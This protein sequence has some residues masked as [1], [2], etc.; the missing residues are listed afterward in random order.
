[1]MNRFLAAACAAV[2]SLSA[3]ACADLTTA[4]N[5]KDSG[6]YAIAVEN[7]RE[8]AE[9]GIPEAQVELAR[10]YL[11]GKGVEKNPQE[12]ARLF[13]NA[14]SAGN[15][16]AHYELARLYE[17]GDGVVKSG[18]KA[19]AYY[20]RAIELGYKGPAFFARGR[21]YDRGKAVAK[22]TSL[23]MDLYHAAALE[24]YGRA[25]YPLGKL[26]EARGVIPAMR[27]IPELGVAGDNGVKNIAALALYYAAREA[28]EA[29]AQK[30]IARLES[31]LPQPALAQAHQIRQK[32]YVRAQKERKPVFGELASG[33]IA[34]SSTGKR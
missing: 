26:V 17:N 3:G 11:D 2:L 33:I 1:M 27:A 25:G 19:D 28:G 32:Y 30:E 9:F 8:L 15:P 22:N 20:I 7:Y 31:T 21:M 12:A 16:K 4:R 29:K 34:D 6:N 18:Q 23:A 13:F 14:A 24:G 10:L 5:A